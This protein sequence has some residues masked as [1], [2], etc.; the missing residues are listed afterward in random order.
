MRL[1]GLFSARGGVGASLMSACTVGREDHGVAVHAEAQA[2][3]RRAIRKDMAEMGIAGGAADLHPPHAVRP[4]LDLPDRFW[5]DRFE[6]AWPATPGV[7][8]RVG[9]EQRGVAADARIGAALETIP[10]RP[11]EG[12]LGAVLAGDP[13]LL[14]C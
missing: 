5:R 8:L 1:A 7:E 9:P 2:G 3:R 13:I 10:E 4:V 6:E 12:A 11:R 14:R